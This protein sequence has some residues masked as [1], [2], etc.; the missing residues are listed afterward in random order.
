MTATLIIKGRTIFSVVR[1]LA[2][3]PGAKTRAPIWLAGKTTAQ[4][5]TQRW[6]KYLNPKAM[7][8]ARRHGVPMKQFTHMLTSRHQIFPQQGAF[9]DQF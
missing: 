6:D 5:F 9:V 1:K 7:H 3:H 2:P 4:S 8:G